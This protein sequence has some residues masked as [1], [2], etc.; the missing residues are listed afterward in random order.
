[1]YPNHIG[2]CSDVNDR[3]SSFEIEKL[4]NFAPMVSV[5]SLQ[6]DDELSLSI[7]NRVEMFLEKRGFN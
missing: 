2:I 7:K 4:K 3:H 6:E 5:P 1:M